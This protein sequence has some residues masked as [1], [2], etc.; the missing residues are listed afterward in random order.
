VHAFAWKQRVEGKGRGKA[1]ADL[2]VYALT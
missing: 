1:R 2:R